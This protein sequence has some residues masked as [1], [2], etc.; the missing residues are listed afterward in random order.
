[1]YSKE[2]ILEYKSTKKLHRILDKYD[3]L[4]RRK[5]EPFAEKYLAKK[6]EQFNQLIKHA[7]L[8]IIVFKKAKYISV[9]YG[10]DFQI[11]Y[12]KAQSALM[13]AVSY[14]KYELVK[15]F[16]SLG[17]NVNH[18]KTVRSIH[19]HRVGAVQV[20]T[21]RRNKK[22]IELLVNNGAEFEDYA[23]EHLKKQGL[24]PVEKQPTT[25]KQNIA[26]QA[27]APAKT[28]KETEFSM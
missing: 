13:W 16:I 22:I 26:E 5:G 3:S 24:Y 6:Q 8:D 14:S 21:D 7:D 19:D 17:A 4:Y 23:V 9:N 15:E 10:E 25:E 18:Y 11:N 20:A 12:K 28:N 27:K 1:M 2:E